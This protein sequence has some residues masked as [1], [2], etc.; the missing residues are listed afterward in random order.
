V[1][2]CIGSGVGMGEL[3]AQQHTDRTDADRQH[4]DNSLQRFVDLLIF[5]VSMLQ[6]R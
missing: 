4:R 2:L 1:Y 5:V 3:A 6:N